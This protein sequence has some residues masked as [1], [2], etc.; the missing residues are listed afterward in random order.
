V[1]SALDEVFGRD[2]IEQQMGAFLHSGLGISG[3]NGEV[4]LAIT[5]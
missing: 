1:T 5:R 4:C 2:V 3:I